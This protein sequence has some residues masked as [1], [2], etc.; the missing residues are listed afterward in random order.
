MRRL[1]LSLYMC[2]CGVHVHVLCACVQARVHWVKRARR[3]VRF[4]LQSSYKCDPLPVASCTKGS[5]SHLAAAAA[6]AAVRTRNVLGG[7]L[8]PLP[9]IAGFAFPSFGANIRAIIYKMKI[10]N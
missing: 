5:T 10:K 4:L 8:L 7:C 3:A 6:A 9:R 2:V 1:H